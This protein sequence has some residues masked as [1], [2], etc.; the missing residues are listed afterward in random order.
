MR[1]GGKEE[2][3]DGDREQK[4]Q[5][6]MASSQPS[7]QCLREER[8]EREEEFAAATPHRISQLQHSLH[9]GELLYP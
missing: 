5:V 3:G 7:P 6:M 1:R 9:C 4:S 2:H 8:D